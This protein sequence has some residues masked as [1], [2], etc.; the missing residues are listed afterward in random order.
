MKPG[1]EILLCAP[2]GRA[3][4]RM[5]EATGRDAYTIHRLLEFT[6]GKGSLNENLAAKALK[7]DLYVID[8]SSMINIEL[9]DAFLKEIKPG[10]TVIFVGDEKHL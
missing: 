3:A 9:A 2:T 4:Q 7:A 5:S 10:A 1:A 6:K 8:E